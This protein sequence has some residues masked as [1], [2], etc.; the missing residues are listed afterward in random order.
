MLP[1]LLLANLLVDLQLEHIVHG[2]AAAMIAQ[3]LRESFS[4]KIMLAQGAVLITRRSVTP[5][6]VTVDT[7]TLMGD[8]Q[9][10]SAC[11]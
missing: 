4:L 7:R 11:A 8:L 3:I 6:K 2:L 10:R 5:L 9:A 1:Q